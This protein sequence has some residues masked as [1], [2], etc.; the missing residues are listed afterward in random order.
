MTIGCRSL[1]RLSSRFGRLRG[2]GSATSGSGLGLAMVE[3]I[4][5]QSGARLVLRS[6]V[7]AGRGVSATL[8]FAPAP[9][10]PKEGG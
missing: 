8:D 7:T 6:P 1:G 5:R 10:P 2:A 9:Q 3:T 4:A